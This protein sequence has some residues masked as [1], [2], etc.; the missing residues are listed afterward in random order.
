M[1]GTF[2]KILEQESGIE[3]TST[4][5]QKDQMV[6]SMERFT[7]LFIQIELLSSANVVRRR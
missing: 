3:A 1:Q 4:G 6:Y 5:Y 7:Q 2:A